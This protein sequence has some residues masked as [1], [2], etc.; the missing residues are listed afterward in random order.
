MA[1]QENHNLCVR[2]SNPFAATKIMDK[3]NEYLRETSCLEEHVNIVSTALN[4]HSDNLNFLTGQ[5]EVL[6]RHFSRGDELIKIIQGYS[7]NL[8]HDVDDLKEFYKLYENV[9]EEL[10]NNFLNVSRLLESMTEMLHDIHTNAGLFVKSAQSLA[11]LAKNT[12]IKAHHARM[13]GKGLAIIAK[14][15]L[16]LAKLAQRPFSNF[17]T[18]LQNLEKIAKPAITELNKI[19]ELSSRSRELLTK[20]FESLKIIDETTISLQSIIR[21]VEENSV[22][23][24]QLKTS[25]TEGV[26]VLK[27]QLLTSLNTID[28]IS[29]R[30][31]QINA[32]SQI[33]STLNSIYTSTSELPSS[34]SDNIHP[35]ELTKNYYLD[36]QLEFFTRENVRI[37]NQFS[38]EKEPPLFPLHVYENIQ[39]I[40]EQI[41]KLNVSIEQITIHKED[42]GT[43]MT[44]V[45]ALTIHIEDFIKESQNV[46]AHLNNLGIELDAELRNVEMLIA[47]TGKIFTKIKT[48]SVFARIEEGRSV[49]Y[50][51]I[52][53]PI[54]QNFV[55]LESKTEQAFTRIKPQIR[56]L[57]R[58]VKRL[59]QAEIDIAMDKVKHPD[60]SKLKV[61]LDDIIRVFG[62]EKEKAKPIHKIA[63]KLNKDNTQLREL[64]KVYMDS[65]SSISEIISKFSTKHR[66]E[67]IKPPAV[68]KEKNIVKIALHDDP[69]TLK[70]DLRT[71]VTSHRVISNLSV[72]LFQFGEA[73]DTIPALC[74]DY[75]ISQD[76][77]EYL[78]KLRKDLKFQNGAALKIEHIKDALVKA[79]RGPNFSFFDMIAGA[80]DFADSNDSTALG[81]EIIDNHTLRIKL[82]Y[83]FLPLL[84]N[85]AT[86]IADPY[87]DKE[88]P[89]G[90][91]P[92]SITHWEK[93]KRLILMANEHYFEGR[94]A[95]DEL[96]F[97][98]IKDEMEA[99]ELFMKGVLSI[100]RLTGE[101]LNRMKADAPQLLHTIPEL[102]I[103]HLCMNCR[104]DPFD[105]KLVRKAIAHG[106]DTKRLVETCLKDDAIP[107]KGIFPPSFKVYNNK[108]EGNK[109]NPRKARE[110]LQEAGFKNGL[111]GIYPFDV[112]DLPSVIKRAEFIKISLENIGVK[113]EINPM[114]WHNVLEKTYAGESV[115]AFRGWVSDN[116]DVDNFVYPMFHS[117]SCGRTG[118]TFFFSSFDIDQDIDRARKIRNVSQRN[119]LYRLIEE[120]IL[121]ESPGVFLYHRLQNIAIQK[122]LLGLKPHFLGLVRAKNIYPVGKQYLAPSPSYNLEQTRERELSNLVHS[123]P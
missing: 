114:P 83:P 98:I 86:N 105:N 116:G 123:R 4:K 106:I 21:Q 122:N 22:I 111:P 89:V 44:D 2:G 59:K 15:C 54:V 33:L 34:G 66:E 69:L 117:S 26:A 37:F 79:L 41:N 93:G 53:S 103:Q 47:T 58:Q 3:I 27:S 101:A 63:E 61:F 118:N 73:A 12:E 46:Y 100:Y 94:P 24:S 7:N 120:K 80:S 52:I 32:L 11:N 6:F 102:S 112:S 17:G 85:L 29:I 99:Y 74:E 36:R 56:H 113:V 87:V 5:L 48:L 72:G 119:Q 16:S 78:F 121:D 64:W 109:Y 76:G 45:L 77:T 107:A 35:L 10:N 28:D 1:E 104:K 49:K 13:E 43:G 51:S 84:A 18:L 90:V 96:H 95:V 55:D 60:Y 42:L 70:P 19:I 68:I 40:T 31:A 71:D 39:N 8:Q 9:I 30:C 81:L 38:V 115:L 20:S 14:E 57:R 75:F 25:I 23:N 65:I 50:H 97:L 91:G 62:E 82:E 108:L 88:L 92:F 110:L 67:K